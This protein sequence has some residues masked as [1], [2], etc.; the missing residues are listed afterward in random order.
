MEA[1][2][3]AA[4]GQLAEPTQDSRLA[5]DS[6]EI[7]A[8]SA[9]LVGAQLGE[10]EIDVYIALSTAFVEQGA[11]SSG[12]VQTTKGS[13]ARMVYGRRGGGRDHATV[14]KALV[15]LFGPVLG[16]VSPGAR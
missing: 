2:F 16:S 10:P 14:H 15:N 8:A 4:V 12:D 9:R 5:I 11:Q 6:R 1:N 13:L 7:L 3:A